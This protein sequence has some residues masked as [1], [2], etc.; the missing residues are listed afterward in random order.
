MC[1][2]TEMAAIATS[3]VGFVSRHAEQTA[4]DVAI[5]MSN[6][7][8]S[9]IWFEKFCDHN[10]FSL[11]PV[12]IASGKTPDYTLTLDGQTVIVE[13]KEIQPTAEERESDRLARE[14]GYGNAVHITPGERVRKKIGDCSP[15][16]KARSSGRHPGLLV[17]WEGGLCAGRHSE[18][19]HIRVAMAGFE[20]VMISLPAI[21]SGKSPSPVGMQHGGKRKMTDSANTSISAVG[22]LCVPGPDQMLLQVY[23][24]R[25]AAIPLV[26]GLFRSPE[27]RHFALRD[28]P[29]RTTEWVEIELR[30]S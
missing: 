7:T 12:P 22:V 3:G 10:Q 6:R 14:R 26:P 1:P 9:E 27:V 20:Q 24:N 15:Q 8:E 25:H 13:V 29:D 28:D 21:K 18:P 4:W 11:L 30:Q 23:H 5:T 17:L 2:E 19:Y 16:I